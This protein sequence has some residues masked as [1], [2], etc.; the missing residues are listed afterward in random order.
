[1]VCPANT[2]DSDHYDVVVLGGAFSGSSLGLLLK[3][4]RP[5]LRVL[6]IEKS[7]KFDRKVGESASEVGLRLSSDS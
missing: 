1:M 5:D 7:T 6:I 4:E 2:P 3:R